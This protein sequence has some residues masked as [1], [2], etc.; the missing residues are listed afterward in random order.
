MDWTFWVGGLVLLALWGVTQ[1]AFS[2]RRQSERM[3]GRDRE[4]A[5]AIIDVERQ[6][7]RGRYR[8]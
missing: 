1:W 2:R 6:S 5:D 8:F 3:R 7:E 4:Q